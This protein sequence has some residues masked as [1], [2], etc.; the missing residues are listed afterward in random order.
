MNYGDVLTYV[1][2]NI[3]YFLPSWWQSLM[4]TR[5]KHEDN[6]IIIMPSFEEEKKEAERKKTGG[7]V[8]WEHKSWLFL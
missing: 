4:H 7:L 3:S 8:C 1:F 2:T 6:I 5:E